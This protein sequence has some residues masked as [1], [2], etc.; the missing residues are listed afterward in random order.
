VS[1]TQ[2]FGPAELA[3]ATGC[4]PAIA[5]LAFDRLRPPEL[6]YRP[7]SETEAAAAIAEVETVIR[8]KPL[9]T[10]GVDDPAVWERGWAE[11]ADRLAGER[12]TT[13]TL[14]PQ[15]YH[16]EV[17]CRLFGGLVEQV[18]PDFE[19]WVGLCVRVATFAEF[20]RGEEHIVEFG[21]G[22]GINLLLLSQLMPGVHLVGCDWATPS[23]RILAQIARET[24]EA[25]EGHRF[26]MLTATGEC[27]PIGAETAVLTVHALEQVG[28][29][30]QPFLDFVTARRPRL[31]VHLEPLVELYENTPLDDL[32]RRYHRKRRY[33]DGFVPAI[34]TL[35]ARGQAE[36]LA[37]RRT[38]FSGLYQEAYSV[39]VW[40]LRV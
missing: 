6:I 10:V 36:I 17:P 9:R 7:L 22:T 38:A 39:L 19:Y 23:Q 21:C 34:K 15:Y 4:S 33:L 1:A 5:A 24:G 11:L 8:D 16:R 25:I 12:I 14:R 30:W 20:L 31:C 3:R 29:G 18:T 28:A 13:H 32:G 26:N 2:K 27:G 40:R 37:L 35:A